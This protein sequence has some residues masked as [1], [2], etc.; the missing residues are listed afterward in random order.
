[1]VTLLTDVEAGSTLAKSMG[2]Y[3]QV[4]NNVYI[5]LIAAGEASGTLDK[6]LERLADQQEKDADIVSKVRGAMIYPIIVLVVMIVVVTFMLVK[7][8]PQVKTLYGETGGLTL[9]LI[10][11]ILLGCLQHHH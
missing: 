3:P 7:V 6:A 8:L 9:P 1:M 4:F 2:K 10:T 5:S 11:Q